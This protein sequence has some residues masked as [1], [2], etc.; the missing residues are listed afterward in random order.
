M[1]GISLYFI[2]ISHLCF[3]VFFLDQFKKANFEQDVYRK[4]K[5]VADKALATS[6]YSEINLAKLF[7]AFSSLK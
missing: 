3:S 7:Q 1:T 6:G 5:A 4:L 2:L